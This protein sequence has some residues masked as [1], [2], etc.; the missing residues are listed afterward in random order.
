[1][2]RTSLIS[3]TDYEFQ[4]YYWTHW[5]SFPCNRTVP[6]AVL[7]E[8]KGILIHARI[9]S[10]LL[11]IT[12]ALLLIPLQDTMTSLVSTSVYSEDQLDK[13]LGSIESTKSIEGS[14]YATCVIGQFI[15]EMLD[16]VP[17]RGHT[18]RTINVILWCAPGPYLDHQSTECVEFLSPCT[19]P[20]LSWIVLCT[21]I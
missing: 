5:E 1:M 19:I 7:S 12:R 8:L 15:R 16:Y 4:S 14:C 11:A 6:P 18:N 9:G 20:E 3:F 10:S 21:L 13:F 2:Q 17:D